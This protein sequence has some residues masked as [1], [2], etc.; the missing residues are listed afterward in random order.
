MQS[1]AS[2]A[3]ALHSELLP[4]SVQFVILEDLLAQFHLVIERKRTFIAGDE[5]AAQDCLE[6]INTLRPRTALQCRVAS[7]LD[8]EIVNDV[9]FLSSGHGF[10][11]TGRGSIIPPLTARIALQLS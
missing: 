4:S 11:S 7:K 8:D 5:Q 10:A 6:V 2:L 3:N 1:C 9:S